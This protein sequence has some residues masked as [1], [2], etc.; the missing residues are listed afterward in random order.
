M[1]LHA[2]ATSEQSDVWEIPLIEG[3]S[4]QIQF[5]QQVFYKFNLHACLCLMSCPYDIITTHHTL[6]MH[7]CTSADVVM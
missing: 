3:N 6:L 1:A 5:Y 4:N 2:L 7:V